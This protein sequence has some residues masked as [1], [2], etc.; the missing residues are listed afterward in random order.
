MRGEFR[1]SAER[2]ILTAFACALIL[3]GPAWAQ[4]AQQSTSA[5]S[6]MKGGPVVRTF[7]AA[8]GF[9]TEVTSETKGTLS[10]EDRRQVS[11]LMAQVFQHVDEA[12]RAVDAADLKRARN[13][14]H[15]AQQAIQVI[16]DLLPR[17][18][19]HTKTTAPNG[20]VVYE[21]DREV[22]ENR[23]LM[24]E[25]M[26]VART[27]APILAA[28]REQQA[29]EATDIAGIQV[30]ESEVVTT[31]VITDLNLIETQLN[32]AAFVPQP[33]HARHRSL[34][35][36][37]ASATAL[38]GRTRQAGPEAPAHRRPARPS[39]QCRLSRRTILGESRV[40]GHLTA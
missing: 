8:G 18:M 11:L 10:Q 19:V 23:I 16:R 31:E 1:K 29:S 38:E 3:T 36:T 4:Q 12:R 32:K 27:F 34:L 5:A 14:V 15:K 28:K 24:F 30:V 39:T 17:T 13:E 35:T 21:D 40:T 20:Q 9:R 26:L 2:P 33:G 22:Q 7:G 6:A 37:L 25:G